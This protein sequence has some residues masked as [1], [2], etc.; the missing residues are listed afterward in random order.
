LD[1]RRVMEGYKGT[2]KQKKRRTDLPGATFSEGESK[3]KTKKWSPISRKATFI[4]GE[5]G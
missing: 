5:S 3:Q 2:T 1:R 4:E